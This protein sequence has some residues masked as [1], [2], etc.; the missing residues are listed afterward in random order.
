MMKS[1]KK[2]IMRVLVEKK[3]IR[4]LTAGLIALG[5]FYRDNPPEKEKI[6]MMSTQDSKKD[7]EKGKN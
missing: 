6:V 4:I 1:T 3:I 2:N 7:A 5:H